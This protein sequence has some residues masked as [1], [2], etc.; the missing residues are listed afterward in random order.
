[1]D[2]ARMCWCTRWTARRWGRCSWP[3]RRNGRAECDGFARLDRRGGF[4]WVLGGGGGGEGGDGGTKEPAE[5]SAMDSRGSTGGGDFRRS[6]RG[7][8]AG[9]EE[10]QPAAGGG[11]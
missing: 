10:P 9:G 6:W 1:M 11:G 7:Q 8:G 3:D 2:A 4:L 5:P